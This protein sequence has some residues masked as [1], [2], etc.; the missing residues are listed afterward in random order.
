MSQ[1]QITPAEPFNGKRWLLP[2]LILHPFADR[3]G[4]S[5]LLE[6]S[7]A[8]LMLADVLPH[9]ECDRDE[10][11]RTLL[12]GRYCEICMLYYVGKDLLRWTGQCLE[13]VN[14]I[15]ELSATGIREQSFSSYLTYDPPASVQGKLQSWGVL[16]FRSIFSRSFALNALLQEVPGPAILSPHFVEHYHRYVDQIFA[17]YQQ[18]TPFTEITSSNFDFELYASGEYSRMLAK[19]WERT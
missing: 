8:A 13:F 5:K 19:E 14:S 1:S 17:S 9:G 18:L 16:D 11:T 3:T 10:L 2:P 12:S 6:S 7:R 15:K 4:P